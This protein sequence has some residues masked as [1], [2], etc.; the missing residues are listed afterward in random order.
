MKKNK[1]KWFSF[2][3]ILMLGAFSSGVGV[4][5]DHD[6]DE[7]GDHSKSYEERYQENDHYGD[8]EDDDG[9]YENE[10]GYEGGTSGE[11]QQTPAQTGY[12]NFWMREAV[13][14]QDTQL[15]ISTPADVKVTIDG[16]ANSIHVIPQ[17]GQLLVSGEKLAKLISAKTSYYPKSRILVLK[18]RILS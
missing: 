3:T 4:L 6:D 2:F 16:V 10:D 15:P 1:V 5:A 8:D 18:I 14:T 7:K 9:D 12:W 13:S 17:D 11:V